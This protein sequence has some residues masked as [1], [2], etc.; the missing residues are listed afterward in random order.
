MQEEFVVGFLFDLNKEHVVLIRKERPA[1]QLCLLNGVG[2]KVGPEETPLQAIK[3]EFWEEA[4]LRIDNWEH[5]S[6][7][8]TDEWKVHY[9]KASIQR[10]HLVKAES[11]TDELVCIYRVDDLLLGSLVRGVEYFLAIARYGYD[12][13]QRIGR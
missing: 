3:R 11:K 6:T 1:W 12:N 13:H 9:F 2:G 4:G 7:E 8:Y 5:V 10:I